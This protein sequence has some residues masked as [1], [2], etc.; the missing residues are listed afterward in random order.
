MTH[1]AQPESA[2][3][4]ASPNTRAASSCDRLLKPPLMRSGASIVCYPATQVG[5]EARTATQQ[6]LRLRLRSLFTQ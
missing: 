3:A 5:Y 1:P 4:R 2:L 6:W